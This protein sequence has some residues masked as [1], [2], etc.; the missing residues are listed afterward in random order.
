M[1]DVDWDTRKAAGDPVAGSRKLRQIRLVYLH[2][3]GLQALEDPVF[4]GWEI[5]RSGRNDEAVP[6]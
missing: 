1:W 3:A 6:K 2:V 4:G 5:G